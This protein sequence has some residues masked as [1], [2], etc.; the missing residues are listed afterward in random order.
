MSH[1]EV[2]RKK[3][4][5]FEAMMRRFTSR[6]KSSGKKLDL[7]AGKH[8]AKKATRNKRRASK[9]RGMKI[10][11]KR[12]YLIRSGRVSEDAFKRKRGRR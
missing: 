7:R 5:S 10:A 1:I 9:L 3:S 6:E 8:F 4:E 11:A 2:K 12:T